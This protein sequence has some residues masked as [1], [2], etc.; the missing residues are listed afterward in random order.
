[1]RKGGNAGKQVIHLGVSD[2]R[3]MGGF[4]TVIRREH[5]YIS[6]RKYRQAPVMGQ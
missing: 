5:H 2:T 4:S 3:F 6:W 1:M